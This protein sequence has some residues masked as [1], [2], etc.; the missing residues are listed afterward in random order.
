MNRYV[1]LDVHKHFIEAC[2]VDSRG[3][4]LR[5]CQVDC[6]RGPLEQFA[7]RQLKRSDRVAL[8]ATTN[9]WPIV[10]LLRPHVRQIVVGNPLKTKAIAEAKIKTDKVDAEVLAQLLRCRYLPEVWQPDATTQAQRNLITHRTG[11]MSRRTRHKNRIQCL[12]SRLLLQP[13]CPNLWSRAGRAWLAALPLSREQ[14]LMLDSE[15]RQ[16][17]QTDQELQV[18][19]RE[20]VALAGQEPRIRL[21]M[22]L[23]GVN[24]VVALGLLSALGDVTRFTDGDHAAAYLGLV[25]KTRQ[26]GAKCYHGRITK[27][28]NPQARW[29]LTQACQ[30]VARHPGPLGA[31][32]RRLAR[33]KP[34]QVALMAVARKLVTVAYHMLRNNEPYRYAQP[35]LMATKFTKL[36]SKSAPDTRW[37][38]RSSS[39]RPAART[40]LS[41]IYDQVGLPPVTVPAALPEGER[42]MLAERG[43]IE[44]AEQL[45]TH[46]PRSRPKTARRPAK[47]TNSGRQAKRGRSAGRPGKTS[48]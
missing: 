3:R 13:P 25:P 17:D 34:R 29:L 32:F 12:L 30:H 45:Y 46:Q 44:F 10:A 14:R 42:R 38:P 22:T 33:R 31:F 24:Y 35:G 20:L 43:L 41:A 15:L 36:R 18:L 2:F 37:N 28:G 39:L 1:G 26:S 27:A 9:T 40:G 8:E 7:K 5:R 11:L 47:S 19:D 23:P 4:V 6:Q 16:L 48:F 21:L